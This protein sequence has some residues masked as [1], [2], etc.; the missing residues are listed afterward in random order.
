MKRDESSTTTAL[1]I[2]APAA[3]AVYPI[4]G[5]VRITQVSRHGIAVCCLRGMIAPVASPEVDGWW[6]DARAIRVLQRL[7]RLRAAYGIDVRS[8]DD[9]AGIVEDLGR[10]ADDVR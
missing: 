4:E 5:V 3:D 10:L 9:I 8:F 2:F 1:Q 7:Q 6:F